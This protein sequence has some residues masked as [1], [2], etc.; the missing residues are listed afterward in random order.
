MEEE[1]IAFYSAALRYIHSTKEHNSAIELLPISY[2]D[3]PE[4]EEIMRFLDRMR[5]EKPLID[6][7]D[8]EWNSIQARFQNSVID[9]EQNSY[10][11]SLS[12]FLT[13]T[14]LL[15]GSDVSEESEDKITMM[16]VHSAKGTEFPVVIMIGM[17]QGNFPIILPEQSESD[18]EEERRLCYVGMTRAKKQLYMTSVKYRESDKE[19]TP[20]Q[21][22]WEIQPDLIKTIYT[23]QIRKALVKKRKKRNIII[24]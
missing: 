21:F 17:E 15:T 5:G 2:T 22:I 16:T 18:L 9:F 3:A 20:S 19:L 13:Y 14:A 24:S 10:D 6:R 23:D 1:N 12:A 7:E 11:K 8:E 4:E